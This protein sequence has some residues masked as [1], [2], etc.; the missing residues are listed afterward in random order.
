MSQTPTSIESVM[1]A[2]GDASTP[3]WLTEAGAAHQWARR[4]G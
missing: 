2:N 3:L 4:R 1:A